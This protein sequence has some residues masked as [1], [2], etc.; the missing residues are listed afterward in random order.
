MKMCVRDLIEIL[1][2]VDQDLPLYKM[3]HSGFFSPVDSDYAGHWLN[4]AQLVQSKN[5]DTL[6]IKVSDSLVMHHRDNF[7]EEFKAVVIT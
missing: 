2:K 7:G 1:Q 5:N 3:D 6:F 4:Y